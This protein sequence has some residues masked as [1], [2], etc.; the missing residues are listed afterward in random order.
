MRWAALLRGVNVGGRKVIMSDLR[1]FAEDLGYSDIKTLLASGNLIFATDDTDPAAIEQRLEAE[2]ETRLGL[3]TD[4][5]V[6]NA[7]DL[8]GVIAANPFHDQ[9]ANRP[10]HLFVHFHRDPVPPAWVEAVR[11]EHGGREE[12]A[13][14]SRELFVDF[15]D[16][17]AGGFGDSK[18]PPLM[19]TARHRRLNTARNWNTVGKLLAMLEG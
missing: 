5:L 13:A 10:N 19:I 12:I 7:E 17:L 8:R 1:A 14:V 15:K 11:A 9:A 2:A 3:K 4:F 6:R 16:C 18:L